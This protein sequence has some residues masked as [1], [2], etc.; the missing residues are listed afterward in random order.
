MNFRSLY[1][2]IAICLHLVSALMAGA[3]ANEPDALWTYK[4]VGGKDLQMSV[5]LPDNYDKGKAFPAF[6]V[7][8]GGSWRTG[9]A[10]S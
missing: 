9:E 10:S 1:F 6:V 8:H 7:F 2:P 5:F 3:Y 4:Q